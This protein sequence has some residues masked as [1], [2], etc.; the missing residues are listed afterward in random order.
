MKPFVK[1]AGGKRSI[2]NL[3]IKYIEKDLDSSHRYYE[4]FLGGGSVFFALSHGECVINDLN[5]ELINCYEIIRDCPKELIKK[6]REHETKHCSEY[7]YDMR[8]LDRNELEY[9]KMSKIDKAARTIYLNKTCFNGLYRVNSLGYFNTPVGKYN[10]PLICDEE[11]INEISVFLNNDSI[12]IRNSS[13]ENCVSDATQGDFIYFDP[14]YD[15][16]ESGFT[17]YVKEGFSSFDLEKLKTMCDKL[18]EKGCN[19]LISNN[20]TQRVLKLFKDKKYEIV[21]IY[22]IKE[23]DVKRTISCKGDNRTPAREVLIYGHKK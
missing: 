18:I 13:F 19:V 11:N 2:N 9:R 15:F 14:P 17:Q 20:A 12:D 21:A 16:E 8:S 5:K 6:L 22:E 4:P 7:F 1:W 3:I 23:I 10:N